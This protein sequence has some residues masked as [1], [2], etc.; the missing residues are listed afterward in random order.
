[1][2]ETR[3]HTESTSLLSRLRDERL[4]GQENL[5][6]DAALRIEKLEQTVRAGARAMRCIAIWLRSVSL[7]SQAQDMEDSA[8]ELDDVVTDEDQSHV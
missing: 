6:E 7:N 5:R 2:N 3:S 8:K 4:L 1:M